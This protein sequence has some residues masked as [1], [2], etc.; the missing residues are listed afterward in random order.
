MKRLLSS[1]LVTLFVFGF[2]IVPAVHKAHCSD[3]DTDHRADECP[4]CH[5]AATV[6]VS[7]VPLVSPIVEPVV[8]G[9]VGVAVPIAVPASQCGPAQ[10]RAPPACPA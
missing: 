7:S 1:F 2:L 5:L 4:V 6:L 9:D 3:N 8:V 10:A